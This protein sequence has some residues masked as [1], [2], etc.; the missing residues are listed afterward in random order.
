LSS[1]FARVWAWRTS[2][3]V[4]SRRARNFPI[5]LGPILLGPI[6][7]GPILLGPILL[8]P[9]LLGP[10]L[11][12]LISCSPSL[13]KTVHSF[14]FSVCDWEKCRICRHGIWNMVGAARKN[15]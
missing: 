8:G 3:S 13:S 5:L 15:F 9:I 7:L 4:A 11:L 2:L 12:G 10:I 14:H 6:L 1:T